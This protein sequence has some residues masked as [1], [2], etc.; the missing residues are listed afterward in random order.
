MTGCVSGFG[1]VNWDISDLNEIYELGSLEIGNNP[2]GVEAG[3]DGDYIMV[4]RD[5][6]NGMVLVDNTDRANPVEAAVLEASD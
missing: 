3:N 5:H 2:R 6:S 4:Q 1:L